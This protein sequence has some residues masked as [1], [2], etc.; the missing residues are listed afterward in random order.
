MDELK[1]CR[2]HL[3]SKIS[4]SLIRLFIVLNPHH[5]T[6]SKVQLSMDIRVSLLMKP[7]HTGTMQEWDS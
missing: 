2:N 1:W 6:D 4:F 5:L 7:G 3:K